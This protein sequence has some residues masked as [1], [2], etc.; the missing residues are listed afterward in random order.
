MRSELRAASPHRFAP[1]RWRV[2]ARGRGRLP[3]RPGWGLGLLEVPAR[4]RQI[5]GKAVR[6]RSAGVKPGPH[7]VAFGPALLARTRARARARARSRTRIGVGLG[8]GVGLGG[9]LR[10]GLGLGVGLGLG[11][12]VGVGLG[13][14]LG[15]WLGVGVGFGVGLWLWLGLGVGGRLGVGLRD[16]AAVGGRGRLFTLGGAVGGFYGGVEVRGVGSS[17]PVDSRGPAAL[18]RALLSVWGPSV[19]ERIV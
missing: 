15:L 12:G 5:V 10:L 9:G 3:A 19:L 11:L 6:P 2:G 7:R 18:A 1:W 14:G 4:G 17:P 16:V 8:L 13:V